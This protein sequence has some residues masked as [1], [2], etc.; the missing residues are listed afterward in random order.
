M[1]GEGVRREARPL[2]PS[3][4][5]T[6][7]GAMTETAT[8]VDETD[9]QLVGGRI[10]CRRHGEG[11]GVPVICIPGLSANSVCLDAVG[12]A[13]AAAGRTAV[14]VDL[15]G[16]GRSEVTP[17]GSYGWEAHARDI[18]DLARRLHGGPVDV[19]GHSMGAFVALA[20]AAIRPAMV[21]RMVLVD[22]AGRPETKSLP[23][24]MA[25]VERLGAVAPSADEY[26]AQIR[27]RGVID[28]WSEAWE[29]SYRY[30]LVEAPGGVRSTTD[31][32]AV[33]EDVQW[34]VD[35]DQRELW[36]GVDCPSLIVKAGRPIGDGGYILSAADVDA[37]L[38]TVP[39]SRART[40]DDANHY[41]VITNPDT[42][43]AIVEFLGG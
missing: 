33:M 14:A 24:I 32:E 37:Y 26:V 1:D 36:S 12:A 42:A 19:V 38:A 35:N 3:T 9:V 10:H 13:L 18:D 43:A 30:E 6:D 4:P 17:P 23:P 5:I 16:R 39:G 25:A 7:E 21:R 20:T 41:T 31:R 22:G 40:I 15:R 27:A 28:P 2:L 8:T 34:G 11:P 29:R